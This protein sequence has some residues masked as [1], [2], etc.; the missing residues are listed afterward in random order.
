MA[1]SSED[2]LQRAVHENPDLIL[3]GIPD[4]DPDFCPDSPRLVSLGREINLASGPIDNLFA[5]ANG[6]LTFVECK[7]HGNSGLKRNVYPQALNYASDLSAQ[8][9]DFDGDD[10]VAEFSRLIHNEGNG[11]YGDMAALMD[12][13]AQD[14]ILENK[15]LA[16]WRSQ[17]PGRLERNVK[18]GR[19]RIVILCAPGPGSAFAYRAVRNLVQLMSFSELPNAGYDLVLMDLRGSERRAAQIIW[20]RHVALPQIPLIAQ[21]VRNAAKG[22]EVMESRLKRLSEADRRRFDE[23]V[24][25][26]GQGGIGVVPDTKGYALKHEDTMKSMYVRLAIN[27]EGGW[28]IVRHQIRD[29][30]PLWDPVESGRLNEINELSGLECKP[31]RSADSKRFTVTIHPGNSDPKAL[32][33][34]ILTLRFQP[35]L[36]ETTPMPGTA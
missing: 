20:R 22:T 26:L 7:L 31:E 4:I 10:F 6:I 36:G 21:N 16:Q 33:A 25:A 18:M 17:F 9:T 2:D 23:L 19:C 14:E 5:D 34:A 30:E 11:E 12:D 3:K 29:K 27:E 15:D 32:K 1:F 13:L 28:S 24:H 35:E 8:L